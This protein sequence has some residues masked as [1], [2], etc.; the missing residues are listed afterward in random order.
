[1]SDI[2]RHAGAFYTPADDH[3]PLDSNNIVPRWPNDQARAGSTRPSF[4]RRRSTSTA[5]KRSAIAKVKSRMKK[6]HRYAKKQFNKM[7]WWQKIVAW[8][9]VFT[10]IAAALLV[11]VF[12]AELLA[13]MLPV[14][15]QLTD[16][17]AGWLIIWAVCYIS[18][19]PPLFGYSTS[20]SMAGFVYG[21]PNGWFMVAT[22]TIF[23]STSAFLA[24]RYYFRDFAQ[25]MV[26]TDKR[27]AA[28][29]LTLKHDGL[30]LLCMIRLCPLPYSISNGAISTF[31]TVSPWAF[32]F[33]TALATP[34]LMIHIFVGTRLRMLAK[35]GRKMDTKTKLINY[36]SLIFGVA[37]FVVTGWLIYKRTVA[38]AK[39]LEHEERAHTRANRTSLSSRRPSTDARSPGGYTDID[40][41]EE[42]ARERDPR[43]A[44]AASL[45]DA[46]LVGD[47]FDEAGLFSDEDLTYDD[48]DLEN[49]RAAGSD[50]EELLDVRIGNIDRG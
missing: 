40:S 25:R 20:V 33:A 7:N 16:W 39:K 48:S 30:K 32:M 15:K 41:D 8:L 49:Q 26:A 50:E 2:S 34:K 21:F 22:A 38:R 17:P 19:F 9:L 42:A 24:C 46:L 10:C 11:T 47:E 3:Q 12:H 43:A 29:S 28:L 35:E 6:I 27:F 5:S 36:G 31:P 4:R 13:M 44:Q 14:A 18:A 45:V 23:G 1:M 37:L